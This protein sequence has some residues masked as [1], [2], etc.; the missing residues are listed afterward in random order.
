MDTEAIDTER[1]NVAPTNGPG[2]GSTVFAALSSIARVGNMSAPARDT[3]LNR[4][5]IYQALLVEGRVSL[6]CSP[7]RIPGPIESFGKFNLKGRQ[8]KWRFLSE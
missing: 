7:D 8:P 3:R 2:E 1:L 4:R 6:C 5:G